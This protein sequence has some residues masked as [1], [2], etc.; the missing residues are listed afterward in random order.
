MTRND[1]NRRIVEVFFERIS[2]DSP[3]WTHKCDLRH[4]RAKTSYKNFVSH[5]CTA[6]PDYEALLFSEKELTQTQIECFFS[7]TKLSA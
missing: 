3:I 1:S 6:H 2:E 4:K 7:T 5:V